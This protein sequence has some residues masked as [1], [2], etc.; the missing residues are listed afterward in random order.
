MTDSLILRPIDPVTEQE[1]FKTAYSWRS[2]TRK[3]HIQ[4]D[5]LAFDD[6]AS[7]DPTQIVMGL[8][9]G[10]LQAVYMFREW[11]PN[12]LEGHFTSSRNAPRKNVLVGAR[13]VL[14]WLLANGA[15]EVSA[16][17]RPRNTPIRRFV[18]EIG[19]KRHS[20][21]IFTCLSDLEAGTMQTTFIKYVCSKGN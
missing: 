12:Y 5:R 4:P 20:Y 9:N 15:E 3:R 14:E 21:V 11:S 17:V 8:F 6:F 16:F 19:F 7:T 2:K 18:E 1:L 13:H 10:E